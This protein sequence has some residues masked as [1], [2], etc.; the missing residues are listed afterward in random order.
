MFDAVRFWLDL[1]V[2]GYRLDAIGTLF[3]DETLSDH[4]SGL[5]QEDLYRLSRRIGTHMEN[6]EVMQHWLDMYGL[7]HDLPEI[8][9]VM[10]ELRAVV[11]EYDDRVLVGET[12]DLAY[13]GTGEDELHMVFNFPLMRMKR[14]DPV[15]IC[16]NQRIRLADLPPGGWPCNTLNNHDTLVYAC[17]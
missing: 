7:Q 17:W 9:D 1:G 11:D 6:E 13:H 12:E 15:W 3:E 4:R 2:D 8:H 14:L 5:T 16:E 10:R